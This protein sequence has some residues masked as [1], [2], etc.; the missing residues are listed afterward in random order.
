MYNAFLQAAKAVE[1][2]LIFA[3][4]DMPLLNPIP[5]AECDSACVQDHPS[6]RPVFEADWDT[7]SVRQ[8]VRTGMTSQIGAGLLNV[9][10]IWLLGGFP[11]SLQLCCAALEYGEI[12]MLQVYSN[13]WHW[14]RLFGP[15]YQFGLMPQKNCCVNSVNM[16]LDPLLSISLVPGT[17]KTNSTTCLPFNACHVALQHQSIFG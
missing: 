6:L 3:V 9:V 17:L 14:G 7:S 1:S 12:M 10:M 5:A 15:S 11:I 16:A 8:Q 4:R 2:S 13:S